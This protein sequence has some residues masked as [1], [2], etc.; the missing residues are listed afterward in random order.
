MSVVR[1]ARAHVGLQMTL[2]LVAMG[3]GAMGAPFIGVVRETMQ[4]QADIDRDTLGLGVF[5]LSFSGGIVGVVLGLSLRARARTFIYRLGAATLALGCAGLTIVEPGPGWAIAGIAAA[6]FMIALSRPLTNV[7][8]GIFVDLWPSTPHTGVI[9]LHAVNAMGKVAAPVL[10]LVLGPHIQLNGLVY[11]GFF[12]VLAITSL[13]WPRRSIEHLREAERGHGSASL[14]L[15]RDPA[16]WACGAQFIFIAG[17][18]AGATAILGSLATV[19]RPSPIASLSPERWAA[20]VVGVM[21]CGIVLGRVVFTWLSIRHLSA[22]S[23]V[24]LCLLCGLAGLPAAY[25]SEPA[26]YLPAL[27]VTGLCFSATWPAF[28][29]LA[30]RQYPSQTTFLSLASAVSSLTGISGCIA[31]SSWIGAVDARLPLAFAASVAVMLL[32]AAF[33]YLT[34]TGRAMRH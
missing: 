7:G 20:V 33:L 18:E 3:A 25:A 19:L 12:T 2:L 16:V 22:R 4:R 6:W 10:L 23:T 28:F 24:S 11:T 14:K 30:A 13:A 15:P 31:L 5:V 17:A 1:T 27:L 8:N 34:P 21:L 32:F 26:V 29:G 9:L